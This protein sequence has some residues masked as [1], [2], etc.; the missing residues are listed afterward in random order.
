MLR[1]VALVRTE[2][3]HEFSASTIRVSRISEILEMLALTSN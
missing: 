3:S 1:C 2:V